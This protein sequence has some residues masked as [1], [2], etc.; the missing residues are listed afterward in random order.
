MVKENGKKYE[1]RYKYLIIDDVYYESDMIDG[2]TIL[3]PVPKE[4]LEKEIKMGTEIV[5]KL[6]DDTDVKKILMEAVMQLEDKDREKL[7]KLL[8]KS[9]K[10]Y[11]VR[12]RD[13]HCVDIK[14][15][16]FILPI[17]H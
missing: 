5:D 13:D 3:V 10:K 7:H 1:Y 6:K 14:L 4:R 16:N 12:T 9:K 17:I 2:K 8:F 15:G 11:V